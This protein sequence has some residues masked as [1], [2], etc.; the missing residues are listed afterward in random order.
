MFRLL[1]LRLGLSHFVELLR[2]VYTNTTAVIKGSK[3]SFKVAR[4]CRQGGLESPWI[5]NVV[6]D[7][8][9]RVIHRKLIDELGNGYGLQLDYQIPI[10]ETTQVQKLAKYKIV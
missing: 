8:V 10:E 5:F 2:A 4:G 7:S 3:K 1:S 9:Y 6:F